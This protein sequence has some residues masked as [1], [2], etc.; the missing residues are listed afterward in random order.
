MKFI[1]LLFWYYVGFSFEEGMEE[2]GYYVD[3]LYLF[4]QIV[5]SIKLTL[6]YPSFGSEL[7]VL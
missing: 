1:L 2:C 5:L 7:V 6:S 4:E 3:E